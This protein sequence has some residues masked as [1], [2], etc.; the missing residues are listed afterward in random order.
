MGAYAT[1][2]EEGSELQ[3]R[4]IE[5]LAA[6]G[7]Y[8]ARGDAG[9]EAFDASAA[10]AAFA[11][12]VLEEHGKKHD[13]DAIEGVQ[14]LYLMQQGKHIRVLWGQEAAEIM[15]VMPTRRFLPGTPCFL[16][17]CAIYIHFN[18]SMAS[19]SIAAITRLRPPPHPPR[20][21]LHFYCFNIGSREPNCDVF[22]QTR[23][24]CKHNLTLRCTLTL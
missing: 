20:L 15:L 8:Q 14:I 1:I 11:M 18:A 23:S 17:S 2:G 13:Y 21:N 3:R 24:L 12:G 5:I 10:S 19:H 22:Q 16:G 9:A 4:I 7:A 6:A